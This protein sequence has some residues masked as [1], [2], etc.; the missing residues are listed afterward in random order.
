MMIQG[1]LQVP[2]AMVTTEAVSLGLFGLLHG[3]KDEI[4]VCLHKWLASPN[5]TKLSRGYRERG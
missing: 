5:E 2:T 4:N 1:S 3:E